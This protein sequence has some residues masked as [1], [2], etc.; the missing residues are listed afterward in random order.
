MFERTDKLFTEDG[1][2][3]VSLEEMDN[4][5]QT[6]QTLQELN[7]LSNLYA[8]LGLRE[9]FNDPALSVDK[10]V[11]F[12]QQQIQHLQTFRQHN[13]DFDLMNTSMSVFSDEVSFNMADIPKDCPPPN[14][15]YTKARATAAPGNWKHRRES[16]FSPV[17]LLAVPKIF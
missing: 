5:E 10:K 7:E 17:W 11:S 3:D 12:A 16:G 9:R 4:P 14:H 6:Q 1:I 13:P 15:Q 2:A 8:P